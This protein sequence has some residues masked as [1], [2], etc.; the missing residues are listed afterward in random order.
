MYLAYDVGRAKSFALERHKGQM[1][2]AMPYSFHLEEVVEEVQYLI[3][4]Q[5]RSKKNLP[6][7]VAYLHDVVEDTL[8]N[9][10]ASVKS[11]DARRIKK[12]TEQLRLLC[13]K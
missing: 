3:S 6:Y 4:T 2:G 9:L 13:E 11:G 5:T 7:I 10:K 12:Y 8:A 1:Y